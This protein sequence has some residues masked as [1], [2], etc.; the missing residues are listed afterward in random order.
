M[1][2]QY[3]GSLPVYGGTRYQ[4]G[5]GILSSI[6]RFAMPI[7]KNMAMETAKAAPNVIKAIISKK[8][9]PGKAILQGLK[10]ASART[11]SKTLGQPAKKRKTITKKPTIPR[12][13]R[14]A[15][16]DIFQ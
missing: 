8:S 7:L 11:A 15:Q 2:S 14:R 6:A 4:R 16:K 1:Y 12:K 5:G 9:S 13:R 3:G 10:S